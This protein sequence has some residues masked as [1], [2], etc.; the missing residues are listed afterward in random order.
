MRLRPRQRGLDGLA[1]HE[2][3][4]HQPHRLPCGGAHGRNAQPFRKPPIVAIRGF[5]GL[6][7]ARRHSSAHAEALTRNALDFVSWWHE[8]ALAEL[9]LDELVGGARVPAPAAGFREHHQREALFGGE[10]ELAKHVLD[11]A[12]PVVAG[13]DGGDQARRG[14]IDSRVLL[15][16]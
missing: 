13:P 6:N 7:H 10:R 9:V 14:A 16:A 1:K 12:Q 2:W 11:A 4:A 8:V 5:A 15:C 3:T